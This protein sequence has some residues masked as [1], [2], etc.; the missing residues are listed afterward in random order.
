MGYEIFFSIELDYANFLLMKE[1][2]ILVELSEE[3]RCCLVG[4]WD[5]DFI[6]CL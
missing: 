3:T 1:S 2:W 4:I 6:R 5:M